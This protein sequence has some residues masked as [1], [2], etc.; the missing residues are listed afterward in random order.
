MALIFHPVSCSVQTALE[1]SAFVKQSSLHLKQTF[2][3]E[4]ILKA[5]KAVQVLFHVSIGMN[6]F[7]TKSKWE[8]SHLCHFLSTVYFPVC[9]LPVLPFKGLRSPDRLWTEPPDLWVSASLLH[10]MPQHFPSSY[11]RPNCDTQYLV[12][13]QNTSTLH[14]SLTFDALWQRVLF[15]LIWGMEWVDDCTLS[16]FVSAHLTW[17]YKDCITLS[18]L[19]RLR[20]LTDAHRFLW[21]CTRLTT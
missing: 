20:A 21:S 9:P 11:P 17:L 12:S 13:A 2:P 10:I 6:C 1:W 3:R 15:F 7:V 8:A 14:P 16:P 4:V 5:Q 19:H 18:S